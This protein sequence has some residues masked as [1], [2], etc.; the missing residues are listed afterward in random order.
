MDDC[1]KVNNGDLNL[2][3]QIYHPINLKLK[4][5]LE[6]ICMIGIA[7][8]Y[9]YWIMQPSSNI[10]Q[11]CESFK[12]RKVYDS[13][14]D[15]ICRL[16]LEGQIIVKTSLDMFF[17]LVFPLIFVFVKCLLGICLNYYPDT[18]VSLNQRIGKFLWWKKKRALNIRFCLQ[19]SASANIRHV[20]YY[21]TFSVRMFKETQIA[22]LTFLNNSNCRTRCH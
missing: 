4:T 22:Q 10:Q 19:Y 17:L 1:R 8:V 6:Y 21:T 14:I 18:E 5:I 2:V 16:N 7:F 20:Q 13:G 11:L 12:A 3:G 9:I 15:Y